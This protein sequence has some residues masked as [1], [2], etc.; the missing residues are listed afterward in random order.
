MGGRVEWNNL[1]GKCA[2]SSALTSCAKVKN[3]DRVLNLAYMT[4][5]VL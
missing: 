1:L 3:P 4:T 5:V 2:A